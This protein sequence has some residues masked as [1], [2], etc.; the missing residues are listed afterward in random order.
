MA[1]DLSA[2]ARHASG[3][4]AIRAA[5]DATAGDVVAITLPSWCR[6]LD[7]YVK[8]SDDSTDD[9]GKLATTGTDSAAVGNNWFPI[10]AGQGLTINTGLTITQ[11][12]ASPPV[13]YLAAATA[14][15]YAHLLLRER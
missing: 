4:V 6:V 10:P 13:I 7:I 9:T 14:S 5:L 11:P 8:Q 2:T 1:V 15:A 3:T 12:A